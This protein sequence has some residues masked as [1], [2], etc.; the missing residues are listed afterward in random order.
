MIGCSTGA[1]AR[2][3]CESACRRESGSFFGLPALVQIA[4]AAMVFMWMASPLPSPGG[5]GRNTQG[6][7]QRWP[8]CGLHTPSGRAEKRRA[9]GG[10][11]AQH[12]RLR[13]LTRCRCLSGESEANKAS[14]AAPPRA[15]ASQVA[16]KA[17]RPVGPPFFAYFLWRSKESR[18]PA[19]ANS[20]PTAR[21]TPNKTIKS[22]AASARQTGAAAQKT[23]TKANNP[24]T[25]EIVP[26]AITVDTATLAVTRSSSL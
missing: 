3:G 23:Q 4:R 24:I 25:T 18:S 13:R 20:R 8:V 5:R 9:W 17:T 19:G 1:K 6:R 22:I 2:I 16:P 7:A 12:A 21:Q 15:R 26:T 11:A 10:R 14:S